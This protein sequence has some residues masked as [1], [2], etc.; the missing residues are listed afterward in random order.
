MVGMMVS[1]SREDEQSPG[2]EGNWMWLDQPGR[3][4][5]M[6]V[7]WGRGGRDSRL[8]REKELPRLHPTE[9][10]ITKVIITA[11]MNSVRHRSSHFLRTFC[12]AYTRSRFHRKTEFARHSPPCSNDDRKAQVHFLSSTD[13]SAIIS[14]TG[15]LMYGS[16]ERSQLNSERSRGFPGNLR[17]C[18]SQILS[19]PQSLVE[20]AE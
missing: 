7:Q 4:A 2:K 13:S 18:G 17:L 20:D 14:T 16:P 5:I 6:V 12:L 10:T 11:T 8:R 15:R 3:L 9:P 1:S 19:W